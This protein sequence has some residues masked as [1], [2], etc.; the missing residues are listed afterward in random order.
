VIDPNAEV[1]AKYRSTLIVTTDGAP[2]SGLVVSENDQEVEIFDGKALRK[3]PVAEIE[4]RVTQQ[5]SSMPEGAAATLAPSEFVDL[6]EFLA[7][8]T[9]DQLK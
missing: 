6:I 8:Q 9:Q 5:Q 7:A 1:D 2:V 3:I 4:E